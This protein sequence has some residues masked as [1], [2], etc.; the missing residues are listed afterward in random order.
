MF[1]LSVC[2]PGIQKTKICR[3]IILPVVYG[4]ETWSLIFRE[5]LRMKVSENR[6]L[7]EICGPEED[8]KNGIGEHYIMR[9]LIILLLIK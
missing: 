6:V 8:K 4:C 9:S 5:G 3:T 2:Y 1:C 7:R